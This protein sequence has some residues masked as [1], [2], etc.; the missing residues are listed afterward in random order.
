MTTP[1]ARSRH[2]DGEVDGRADWE[3][4]AWS[5][6]LRV[7]TRSPRAG[8]CTVLVVDDRSD[9]RTSWCH[10]ADVL[11]FA[12]YTVCEAAGNED[13]TRL[14]TH[15]RFDVVVEDEGPPD[16]GALRVGDA[17]GACTVLE[18][19]VEPEELVRT[20][21]RAASGAAG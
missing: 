20:V 13:A 10:T 18:K 8:T 21:W 6:R 17:A 9:R 3:V 2:V 11:R 14:L 1:T 12:G 7:L 15:I 4:P 19:P 5:A 16:T